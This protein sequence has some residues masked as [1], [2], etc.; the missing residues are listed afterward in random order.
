MIIGRSIDVPGVLNSNTR[1]DYHRLLWQELNKNFGNA[2]TSV[3][4]MAVGQ[5]LSS[6]DYC[7]THEHAKL[8][9]QKMFELLDRTLSCGTN[10]SPTG[11]S[12][13][14][15]WER[16]LKEAR[17]RAGHEAQPA[18]EDTMHGLKQSK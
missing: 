3:F 6:F 14:G 11:S 7:I 17:P 12:V 4:V 16:L 15:K 2:S 1:V 10:Y 8:A 9:D 13:S 18:F 5:Q